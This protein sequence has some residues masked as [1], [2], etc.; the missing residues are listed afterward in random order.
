MENSTTNKARDILNT[1][2]NAEKTHKQKSSTLIE[3][4]EIPGTPFTM[5]KQANEGEQ[6]QYFI[7][8]GDYRLTEP[9]Y[10][11]EEALEKLVTEHWRIIASIIAI[12]TEKMLEVKQQ[13]E[14]IATNRMAER[15]KLSGL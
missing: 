3:R 10:K 11:E 5:I 7:V 12:T 15:E 4:K 14:D 8:M 1:Q 6:Y 13:K 2:N 9:V